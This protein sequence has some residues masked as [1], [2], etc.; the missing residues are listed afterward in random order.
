LISATV[1]DLANNSAADAAASKSSDV[2]QARALP[3][4]LH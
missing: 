2:L 3:R 4:H 1:F